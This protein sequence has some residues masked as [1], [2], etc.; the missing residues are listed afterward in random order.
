LLRRPSCRVAR[1]RWI[2]TRFKR[3]TSDAVYKRHALNNSTVEV[4]TCLAGDSVRASENRHLYRNLMSSLSCI[5]FVAKAAATLNAVSPRGNH[6]LVIGIVTTSLISTCSALCNCDSHQAH[7]SIA[8]RT[9][10]INECNNGVPMYPARR[11][12][13]RRLSSS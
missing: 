8:A 4:C 12:I 9:I 6:R 11:E 5:L 1:Q 3:S 10:Q 7:R 2:E 13:A